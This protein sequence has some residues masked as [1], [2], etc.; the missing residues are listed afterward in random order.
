MRWRHR[1][2]A[3]E[4]RLELAARSSVRWGRQ[5]QRGAQ[6]RRSLSIMEDMRPNTPELRE[7][8]ISQHAIGV[9]LRQLFDEVVSEPPPADFLEI[10]RRADARED[11]A[12]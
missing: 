4:P 3:M 6:A 2:V 5:E 12:A 1:A 7:A 9:R 10:L 8:R 11:G